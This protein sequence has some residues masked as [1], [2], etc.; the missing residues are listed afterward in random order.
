MDEVE[1]AVE[2]D[3]LELLKLDGDDPDPALAGTPL[4]AF[5]GQP[6][7]GLIGY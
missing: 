1:E 2:L 7:G 6:V 4:P 5:D 3:E